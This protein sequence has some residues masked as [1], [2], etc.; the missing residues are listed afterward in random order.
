MKTLVVN[1]RMGVEVKEVP[2]PAYNE[3]QALVKM[4]VCGICN[5]TDA[6][7]I[8]HTFKG[9]DASDYPLVLGHEGVGRV[10][11]IGAK[12]TG[13]RKGDIVLLPFVDA[14]EKRYGNLRSGWGA[15]SEYGVVCDRESY[16]QEEDIPECAYA[17]TI[18]PPT[19]DAIDGA[20]IIT[21]REVLSSIHRFGIKPEDSVVVFGVGP[22][23][24]TFIKFL[25]LL[26]VKTIIAFDVHDERKAEALEKGA[27]Y[28]Y[29]SRKQEPYE[30]V[31]AICPDGVD[32]VIDAVGMLALINQ[33]MELIKDGGKICCYGIAPKT[34][35]EVDWSKAPYNWSL[36]F[37]QFPSKKEEGAVTE[38]VLNWIESGEIVL[39]DYIS[40]YFTFTEVLEALDKLEN[41]EI[42]KK[43]IVV[44]EEGKQ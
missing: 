4:I 21:I 3:H 5:G 32:Y 19:I 43:G 22:V 17:Q 8:H 39:K 12:V 20:M 36:C 38:Q 1:E 11:E 42:S 13:Y 28:A 15:F 2:V 24:Q 6:K 30:T 40:D 44:F 16:D 10:V 29:N 25:S 27:H 18:V 14:D 35:F 26:N 41:R 9:F 34:Q 31:R 23:G 7:L 37:Q 33:G